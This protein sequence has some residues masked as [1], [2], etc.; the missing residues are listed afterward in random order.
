[1]RRGIYLTSPTTPMRIQNH[2][3]DNPVENSSDSHTQ[4]VEEISYTP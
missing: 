1:M 2:P 3:L 4:D